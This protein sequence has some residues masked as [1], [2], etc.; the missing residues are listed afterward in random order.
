MGLNLATQKL[1][2]EPCDAG[3]VCPNFL[4]NSISSLN[5]V[6]Q[7]LFLR[8]FALS[9][10]NKYCL[11]TASWS[12]PPPAAM[13]SRAKG[14]ELEVSFTLAFVVR[15]TRKTYHFGLCVASTLACEPGWLAC[16][17]QFLQVRGSDTPPPQAWFAVRPGYTNASGLQSCPCC[18]RACDRD[19]AHLST[20][21]CHTWHMN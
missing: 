1:S 7:R 20:V 14:P 9:E 5:I 8:C 11:Q 4:L 18:A 13:S 17:S 16:R 2:C 15:K 21:F 3:R 12:P 10:H 19:H 6:F